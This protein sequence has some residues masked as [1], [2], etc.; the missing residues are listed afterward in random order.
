M[1]NKIHLTI[2][3]PGGVLDPLDLFWVLFNHDLKR[4]ADEHQDFET[5]RARDAWRIARAIGKAAE[6][7]LDLSPA[8]R[9]YHL[10]L[11]VNGSYLGGPRACG[12][13]SS[14]TLTSSFE[15]KPMPGE[16]APDAA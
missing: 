3:F 6:N 7:A 12:K 11:A 14:T 15:V 13:N 9:K 4:I 2:H 5:I 10:I 16:E 8:K 1:K